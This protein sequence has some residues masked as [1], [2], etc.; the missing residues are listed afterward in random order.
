MS[1]EIKLLFRITGPEIDEQV[2]VT[3]QGL[4]VGRTKDNNV[5]LE[6]RE[7][8]RQHLRI[9]W[10]A[11]NDK[12]YAEDLNSSNGTWFND[13]R[14]TPREAR[15][16]RPGDVIRMGP[17][18]LTFVRFVL[19]VT[20]DAAQALATS[21]RQ[22]GSGGLTPLRRLEKVNGHALRDPFPPGISRSRSSWLKY[23]P[24]IYA[25]DE[26][27]GR[28]LLIFESMMSPLMW[29]LDNFDLY[30]S[31]EVAPEDWLHW[32]A[33]WFDVLLV[34]ELPVERKREIVKNL[35]W[36]F[37]RRGTKIQLERLLE[38]YYGVTPEILEPADT[39]CHFVVRLPL[40][41]SKVQLPPDVAER[42][43]NSQRPA[44][45]SFS[46]EIT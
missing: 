16:L 4:R 1:D 37:L 7:V 35:G 34:P 21:T 41:Q 32:F 9:T 19:P 46:L 2:L 14:M 13:T 31:P 6:S 8:S 29:I 22:T 3:R 30:L 10:N 24:G 18:L 43:I 40:S 23:L 5:A 20:E 33:Q 38:L 12:Y 15:E 11:E 26:F 27:T 42:L 28:Y 45:A 25:E 44:F 39:P 17:F 36:L